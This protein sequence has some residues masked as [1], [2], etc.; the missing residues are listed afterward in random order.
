MTDNSKLIAIKLIHTMVWTFFNG[1]IFYLAYAV[2][3]NRIDKWIWICLSFIL[4][5]G[6][7]LLVFKRICPIT[8]IARKYSKSNKENF[9]IYLPNWLAKYNKEI[10]SIIVLIILLILIYRLFTNQV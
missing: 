5:E 8:I 6:L 4:L 10:Y 7:L 2:L 3:I 9:D 1:V